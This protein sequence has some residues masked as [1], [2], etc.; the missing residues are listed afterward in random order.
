VRP[1]KLLVLAAWGASAG[2]ASPT[3]TFNHDVAPVLFTHCQPCHRPGQPVPFTLMD[4][5]DAKR[6]A[7]KIAAAVETRHMPPWLP[8]PG[9]PAFVGERRLSD[10]QIATILAPCDH[11]RAAEVVIEHDCFVTEVAVRSIAARVIPCIAFRR[12]ECPLAFA[13]IEIEGNDRIG[14]FSDG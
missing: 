10:E 7:A 1:S 6:R 12:L 2:C 4:Y 13:R 8:R 9:E 14:G 5:A 11:D 3:P